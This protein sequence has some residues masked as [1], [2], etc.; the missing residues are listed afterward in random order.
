[1]DGRWREE[2]EA[3]LTGFK[4]WRLQHPRATLSEIEAA[5]DARWAVARP[6]CPDCGAADHHARAAAHADAASR[7]LPRLRGGPFPP[8]MRNWACCRGR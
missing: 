3:I 1:M 6:R 8:W 7:G 4:E 2:T 5:L